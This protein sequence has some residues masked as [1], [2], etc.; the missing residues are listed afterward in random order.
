MAGLRP[1]HPRLFCL[2]EARTWMPGTSPGMTTF[3]MMPILLAAF[4]VRLRGARTL[5]ARVEGWK[6]AVCQM[7]RD[8]RRRAPRHDAKHPCRRGLLCMGLFSIFW[9]E[10]ALPPSCG[11]LD[12]PPGARL[13]GRPRVHPLHP[14]F[15]TPRSGARLLRMR[16]ADQ[17]TGA[18]DS[19]RARSSP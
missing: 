18:P 16:S 17:T 1:G 6:Q 19:A 8:A 12:R 11:G 13:A 10:R 9:S 15:E 5:C 4:R 3:E 7:V 14:S 2:T